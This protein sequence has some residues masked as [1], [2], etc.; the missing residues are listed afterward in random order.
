MLDGRDFADTDTLETPPVA[1]LSRRAGE[2]AP[3]SRRASPGAA[4]AVGASIRYFW[5]TVIGIV[6]N[7]TWHQ[8]DD[9]GIEIYF[10]HGQFPAETMRFLIGIP[11]ALGG[12]GGRA[13]LHF[14]AFSGGSDLPGLAGFVGLF[15][16]VRRAFCFARSRSRLS[17][18]LSSS[19]SVFFD[20]IRSSRLA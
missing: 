3:F 18:A 12:A 20:R 2:R 11:M 14:S 4:N 16:A 19:L 13:G 8:A 7:T 5:T 17:S 10:H 6:P 15:P 1:I 9:G